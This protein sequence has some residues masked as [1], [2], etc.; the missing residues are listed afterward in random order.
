[1]L[2]HML[3]EELFERGIMMMG[4]SRDD[5]Q[6][7]VGIFNKDV[8]ASFPALRLAEMEKV[9]W[10]AGDWNAVNKVPATRANPAY[11]DISSSALR[12]CEKGAWICRIGPDGRERPHITFDPFSKQWM[13]VLAE[14]AFGILRSPGWARNRIVFTGHVTM[15][16]VDCE[17]R[18]TW[19]KTS[20]NQFAFL[21]EEQLADGSWGYVDE[22]EFRRK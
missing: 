5:P 2:A 16:G 1:M 6:R 13:Y 18:Q 20:D 8:V 21:N 19:T 22:W 11:A 17:M 3:M 15:I 9:R 4:P 14:G 10:L 12:L 7:Q